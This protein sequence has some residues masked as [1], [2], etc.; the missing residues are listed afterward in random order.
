MKTRDLMVA[1]ATIAQRVPG[2]YD[3]L[4]VALSDQSEEVQREFHRLVQA[5]DQEL[6]AVRK[7]AR[8]PW[9]RF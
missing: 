7:Q 4:E 6:M 8:Q 1:F 2:R 5:F 3:Q 9:R